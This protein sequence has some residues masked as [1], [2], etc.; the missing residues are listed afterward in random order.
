MPHIT[1]S[2]SLDTGGRLSFLR[3]QESITFHAGWWIKPVSECMKPG[4]SMTASDGF[5]I[6]SFPNRSNQERL[7]EGNDDYQVTIKEKVI[8]I[9]REGA[10]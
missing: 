3:K 8:R 2:R 7:C 6:E 9:D 1:R 5:W 4:S 10:K